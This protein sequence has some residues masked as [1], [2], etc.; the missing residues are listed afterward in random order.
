MPRRSGRGVHAAVCNAVDVG[1]S[2][3][4]ASIDRFLP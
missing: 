1:S 2:P 4:F 3:T